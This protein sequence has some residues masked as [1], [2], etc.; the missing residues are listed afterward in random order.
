MSEEKPEEHRYEQTN[1]Y[2]GVVTIPLFRVPKG[3]AGLT[4]T[5]T[6]AGVFK[7]RERKPKPEQL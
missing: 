1:H 6:Y 2:T 7:L 3:E 5:T 4:D